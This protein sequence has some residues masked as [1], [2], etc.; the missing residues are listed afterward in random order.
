MRKSKGLNS[1]S[2]RELNI[3]IGLSYCSNNN[4]KILEGATEWKARYPGTISPYLYNRAIMTGGF[5]DCY[6]GPR[7]TIDLKTK[8]EIPGDVEA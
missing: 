2:D 1:L 7:K 5:P 3:F 4:R 8:L 6:S